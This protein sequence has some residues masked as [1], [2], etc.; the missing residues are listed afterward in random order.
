MRIL[1]FHVLTPYLHL[2]TAP[3][4]LLSVLVNLLSSLALPQFITSFHILKTKSS[5][6]IDVISRD[7]VS[8]LSCL[9]IRS[10][11]SHSPRLPCSI[12]SYSSRYSRVSCSGNGPAYR[13]GRAHPD[14]SRTCERHVRRPLARRGQ[15]HDG[16]L[17]NK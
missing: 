14:C 11:N 9:F 5:C 7:F 10:P 8:P 1:I 3:G 16:Q 17:I 15:G 2:Q 4:L 6:S 13:R 12:S